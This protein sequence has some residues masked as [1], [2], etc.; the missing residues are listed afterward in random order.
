MKHF[1]VKTQK[2]LCLIPV[3][4][5]L[6][7]FV[8]AYNCFVLKIDRRV[9][10]RTSILEGVIV[11]IFSMPL[12]VVSK[13]CGKDSIIYQIIGVL[14]LYLLPLVLWLKWIDTQKALEIE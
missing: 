10:T 6:G 4:N 5:T 2:V 7:I 13:W 11:L 9:L 14:T 8:W 3:V 12:I 1:S